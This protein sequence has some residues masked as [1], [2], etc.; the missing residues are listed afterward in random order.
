MEAWLVDA[1][2]SPAREGGD[3]PGVLASGGLG[4]GLG[5]WPK[6]KLRFGK[7]LGVLCV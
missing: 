4:G 7:A 3:H 5:L 2:A 6:K 1:T